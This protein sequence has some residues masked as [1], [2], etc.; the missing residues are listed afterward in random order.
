MTAPHPLS[1][2]AFV[3]T[4][5]RT[6]R[7]KHHRSPRFRTTGGTTPV[8]PEAAAKAWPGLAHQPCPPHGLELLESEFLA[9]E[10][11]NCGGQ[12]M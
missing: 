3:H 6:P 11:P 8:D 9:V 1:T 2:S 4:A 12:P 10:T 5:A 7:E